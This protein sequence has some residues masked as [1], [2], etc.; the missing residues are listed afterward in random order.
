MLNPDR[1]EVRPSTGPNTSE[2]ARPELIGSLTVAQE[3]DA[4]F[5][6][7]EIL[8]T[9]QT[10]G[11][12]FKSPFKFLGLPIEIFTLR[13]KASEVTDGLTCSCGLRS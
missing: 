6:H 1:F 9:T 2:Q 11:V 4:H 13:C 8:S 12:E 7:T 10:F 5:P 3:I